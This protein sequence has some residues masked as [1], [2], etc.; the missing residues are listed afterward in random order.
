MINNLFYI[1]SIL[2]LYG[3][4]PPSL[5]ENLLTTVHHQVEIT[6]NY[7]VKLIGYTE[8]VFKLAGNI[9]VNN[10]SEVHNIVYRS[11]KST[12]V[13]K[14]NVLMRS[15]EFSHFSL[16]RMYASPM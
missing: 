2:N 7:V 9:K 1:P 4:T 12:R 11:P 15:R 10:T 3:G 5:F 13:L 8:I 16:F 14:G 6:L